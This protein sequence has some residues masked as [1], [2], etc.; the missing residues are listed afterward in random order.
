[1]IEPHH[2]DHQI[3]TYWCQKCQIPTTEMMCSIC[4]IDTKRLI[5]SGRLRPVFADEI[6]IMEALIGTKLLDRPSDFVFWRSGRD[7]YAAGRKVF[8]IVGG[9]WNVAPYIRIY[10][11]ELFECL[12]GY[13][14]NSK[15]SFLSRS[16]DE[17][18]NLLYMANTKH[19]TDIEEEAIAFLQ[20]I[21]ACHPNLPLIVSWSGGK[22]STVASVLTRKA[23]PNEII[24]HVFADTT[25][26]MPSTYEYLKIFRT[27][28][29][30]VPIFVSKPACEF[31]ELCREI[32]PPSRIQRW[33]CTTQ[34]T[35]PLSKIFHEISNGNNILSVGGLRRNESFRRQNYERII[36]NE[37]I[38]IQILL[39]PLIEW[40]DFDV[41]LCTLMNTLPINQA[42]R[43]GID[44][45]GC[46][47]CP[48]SSDWYIMIASYIYKS[49]YDSW[50]NLLIDI[51]REAEVKNPEAYVD[52]GA[53]KNR[54]GGGIGALGLKRTVLYR[55]KTEQCETDER[56]VNYKLCPGFSIVVMH[57]ILKIF[58]EVECELCDDDWGHFSVNGPYGSFAVSAFPRCGYVYVV[59]DNCNTKR[60]LV[61]TLRLQLSKI[62]MCVGCCG[63]MTK[64]PNDAILG[65]GECWYIESRRCNYCLKCVRSIKSGCIAAN[66]LHVR[67][68]KQANQ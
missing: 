36:N 21:R 24:P 65:V 49:Y 37:K 57:E 38:D 10:D 53:W 33:C 2:N 66:S 29:P 60:R 61:R 3:A 15:L 40:T 68:T 7:Y 19:V 62:Q 42:Y 23:F 34:K 35:V 43:S 13:K 20:Y 45:V 18:V 9:G 22:D 12:S 41:W 32:G 58:G 27:V 30:D 52:N 16:V 1:M 31:F 51:F 67:E 48:N 26:E 6:E 39:S 5:T 50:R 63:C 11:T 25:I 56:I 55:I 17:T 64:C 54:R 14:H 28:N 44:R 4:G 47:P 46:A 59:F 8:H